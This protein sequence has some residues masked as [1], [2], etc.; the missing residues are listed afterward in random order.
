MTDYTLETEAGRRES[1]RR[2]LTIR[3]FDT[4][5]GQYFADGEIPGFVHLY[6]GEEAVAV[7]TCA[8]LDPDDLISSTHRGH[9]HCIAKGLDTELMMAELFGKEDGYCNGKGGSMHI[10]DVESGMLG[11]NGI[12]GAGPPLATGAALSIDYQDRDQVALAFLG[13][14]AVAQGQVHEAIN[15]ASTWDLPAIFLVENN[16]YGEATPVE[17]QHNLSQL[18]DTAQAYDIP[19]LTVDG[20]DVTAVA[21]A[22]KE[23]RKR[24]RAGDGPTLIE[25]E[26]YRYRGH[27]E[28]DEQNYRTDEELEQ[29]QERD[30]IDSF[31]RRLIDRGELTEDDFEE[32]QAAIEEAIADAIEYAQESEFPAPEEAYDDMFSESV[33]EIEAFAERIRT[34]GGSNGGDA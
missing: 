4:K 5:A 23:A 1:L 29:W 24:A 15:L 2:M 8:A 22:V 20:M 19:G 13:D 27:Y 32:M 31:K 26:T 30:A 28:G 10:A 17:K 16:R 12:V 25:A 18:S 21:E 11:A 3:E 9:G 33:P 6:I 34:D 14:G 7:G